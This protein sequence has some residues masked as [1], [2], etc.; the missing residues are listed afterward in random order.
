MRRFDSTQAVDRVAHDVEVAETD[1]TGRRISRLHLTSED[2][3]AQRVRDFEVDA[4][5][6]EQWPLTQ[7]DPRGVAPGRHSLR[8]VA[9]AP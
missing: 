4:V 3:T 6:S 7:R 8:G 1:E 5:R 2:Q 9:S